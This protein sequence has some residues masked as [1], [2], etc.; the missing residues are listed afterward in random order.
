MLS[1]IKRKAI[2]KTIQHSPSKWTLQQKS[3]YLNIRI[4]TKFTCT[5][6]SNAVL[7]V[8]QSVKAHIFSERA[9]NM[10]ILICSNFTSVIEL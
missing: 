4:S 3:A 10:C 7:G 9:N 1:S 2:A 8:C 6:K 5:N